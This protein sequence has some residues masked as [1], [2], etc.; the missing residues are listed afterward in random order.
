MNSCAGPHHIKFRPATR[1]H[2][3]FLVSRSSFVDTS[4]CSEVDYEIQKNRPSIRSRRLRDSKNSFRSR[5]RQRHHPSVPK[6][7]FRSQFEGDGEKWGTSKDNSG[8]YWKKFKTIDLCLFKMSDWT[9]LNKHRCRVGHFASTDDFGFNGAFRFNLPHEVRPVFCIASDGLGWQHVSV[10]FG[11]ANQRTP[12]WQTMAAVKD[13]FF[14]Q[15]DWVIQFHPPH[16]EYVNNH[17][18]CLHLWKCIDGRE[19]PTPPSILVGLK[20]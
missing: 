2:R 20:K 8:H 4:C 11:A 7:T 1:P 6:K 14:D 19:Q 17:K 16:S 5:I 12:T 9:F 10:S 3:R 18:G 15:D 13:L